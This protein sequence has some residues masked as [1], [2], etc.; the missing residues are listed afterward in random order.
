LQD[1]PTTVWS[2]GASHGRNAGKKRFEG[3]GRT[4]EGAYTLTA[5][6]PSRQ[7]GRFLAI[8]YPNASDRQYARDHDKR[9]GGA[10]GIHGP[11]S[12][13]AFLGRL[14]RVVDHSDGCIVL[15]RDAVGD[16]AAVVRKPMPLDILD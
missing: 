2:A 4:P 6:R 9:P 5:A 16:L 15:D 7:F 8:S 13:Y 10:V 3:D 11:Q 12:W 14:Q 1:G